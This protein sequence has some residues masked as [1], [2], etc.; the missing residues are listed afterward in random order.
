MAARQFRSDA[1]L[2]GERTTRDA[3]GPVLAQHGFDVLSDQ[4]VVRGTATT[5]VV[6]ARLGAGAPLKAHVRLCWRR[7]GRNP[8]EDGYSAAQLRAKL[9]AGDWERTL[10]FIAERAAGE[11]ITHSLFAQ[12]GREG[13]TMAALVPSE[14]IPF[15]WR[16]QRDISAALIARGATGRWRKN[17]AENG[18]SPTIWLQDDRWP[19]SHAVADV[20][21]T[22][23]GVVNVLALPRSSAG[24]DDAIEDSLDDLPFDASALGR[25]VGERLALVRSGY[26]RDPKVR[27]SVLERSGGRCERVGCGQ[28]REYSGFLDV[29]HILGVGM[30]DRFWSCVALC[31]NCHREA[32]FSPDRDAVNAELRDFASRF[33]SP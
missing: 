17:H 27:A 11:G 8:R 21:W 20:L 29:H 2:A 28:G 3:I 4:R 1:S 18:S 23:P 14:R 6:T 10:A 26:S 22:W 24:G 25:D 32:H 7:D 19:E 9:I 33:A 12:G 31:P 15:I 16:P 5:Q 30:S 13:I